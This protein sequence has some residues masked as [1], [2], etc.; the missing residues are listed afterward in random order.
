[1]KQNSNPSPNSN[2]GFALLV[3][4][5]AGLSTGISLGALY[6]LLGLI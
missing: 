3:V 4:A 5:L 1:M 6:W 2:L